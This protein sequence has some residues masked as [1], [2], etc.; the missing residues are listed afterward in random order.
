MAAGF[1]VRNHSTVAGT[2]RPEAMFTIEVLA[3]PD[4]A[5]VDLDAAQQA[6][7]AAYASAFSE[8]S[9]RVEAAQR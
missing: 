3:D 1:Q 5:A 9:Q 4:W 2:E 8:L 6:L 7:S